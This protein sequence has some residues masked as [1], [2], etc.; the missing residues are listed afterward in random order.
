MNLFREDVC[1]SRFPPFETHVY[2]DH[3]EISM[4][5]LGIFGENNH[6]LMKA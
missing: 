1:F 6:A 3:F 2:C 5:S 4:F